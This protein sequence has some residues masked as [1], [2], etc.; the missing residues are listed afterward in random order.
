M[1]VYIV[2]ACIV[3][4]YFHRQLTCNNSMRGHCGAELHKGGGQLR[5][6]VLVIAEP[7]QIDGDDQNQ[8]RNQL[9]HPDSV[10]VAIEAITT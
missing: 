5:L 4:A 10:A 2:M 7:H 1:T 8:H 9:D 3:I 6:S